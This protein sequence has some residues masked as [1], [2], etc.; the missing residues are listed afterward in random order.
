MVLKNSHFYQS[1]VDAS[2]GFFETPKI[3]ENRGNIHPITGYKT[4]NLK[5]NGGKWVTEYLHRAV[6][7]AYHKKKVPPGFQIMHQNHNRTDCRI[8]NLKLGTPSQNTLASVQN[9]GRERKRTNYR[10]ECRVQSPSGKIHSFKSI[11]ACCRKLGLSES[12]VG[13]GLRGEK[14]VLNAFTKDKN[15]K[16]KILHST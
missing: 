7:Q 10:N 1:K 11:A 5:T 9:R 16:Y 8:S 13:K 4:I 2:Q 12:T 14:Y 15:K 6:W 3:K